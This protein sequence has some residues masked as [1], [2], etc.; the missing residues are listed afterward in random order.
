MSDSFEFLETVHYMSAKAD[1]TLTFLA[2]LSEN[3]SLPEGL[4]P[5]L[6]QAKLVMNTQKIL[7][8]S[9]VEQQYLIEE[10]IDRLTSPSKN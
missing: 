8:S 6:E 9:L 2:A 3:P 1:E 10:M 4:R 7:I 5:H